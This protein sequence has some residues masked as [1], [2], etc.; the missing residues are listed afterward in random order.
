MKLSYIRLLVEKFD[1]CYDFY[2]NILGFE[3]TWGN[4]E[5]SYA[6]FQVNDQTMLSIFRKKYTLNHIGEKKHRFTGE[7]TVC[8]NI[9]NRGRRLRI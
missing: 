1:L 5:E 2:K 8:Y 3:V 6:S 7:S 4:P 9:R